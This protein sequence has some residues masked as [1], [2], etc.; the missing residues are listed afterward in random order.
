MKKI[1][2]IAVDET[3]KDALGQIVPTETYTEPI[4]DVSDVSQ[5]EFMA[6]GQ[7]GLKPEKR[8]SVWE[9]EY[10]DESLIEYNNVRYSVYRTYKADGRIELYTERRI[11]EN[12]G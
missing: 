8:F 1:K 7:K 9:S 5:S 4:A 3:R 11:G 6:G 12:N 10:N 2:L